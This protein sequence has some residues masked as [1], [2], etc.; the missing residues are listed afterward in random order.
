MSS[1]VVTFTP[2]AKCD[3][4]P[5][6]A[7]GIPI[8][9]LISQSRL[10]SISESIYADHA[11]QWLTDKEW[12]SGAVLDVSA[13]LDSIHGGSPLPSSGACS[14]QV[15]TPA[16]C[17]ICSNCLYS[18]PWSSP[19][20]AMKSKPTRTSRRRRSTPYCTSTAISLRH[21]FQEQQQVLF[22]PSSVRDKVSNTAFS[23]E[24]DGISTEGC[25]LARDVVRDSD[26]PPGFMQSDSLAG[27]DLL[28][29]GE[30]PQG[31]LSEN[32]FDAKLEFSVSERGSWEG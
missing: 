27:L 29:L 3:W 23:G 28:A 18:N 12:F 4:D 10:E 17:G 9:A 14:P 22:S 2:K 26:G 16:S 30:G 31:G 8:T 20:P 21:S 5:F 1:G 11:K 19:S 6:L 15:S 7:S 13:E 25:L 24:D 32:I